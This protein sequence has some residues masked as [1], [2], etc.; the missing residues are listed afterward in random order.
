MVLYLALCAIACALLRQ[1]SAVYLAGCLKYDLG[2]LPPPALWGQG[3]LDALSVLEV[4][5]KRDGLWPLL[6]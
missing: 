6:R 5:Y 2:F 4:I 1:D 3:M